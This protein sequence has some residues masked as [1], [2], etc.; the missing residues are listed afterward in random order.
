MGGTYVNLVGQQTTLQLQP[1]LERDA[2]MYALR[3][4]GIQ[5]EDEVLSFAGEIHPFTSAISMGGF[6]GFITGLA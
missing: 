4:G 3:E 1:S 2:V 5:W 6:I